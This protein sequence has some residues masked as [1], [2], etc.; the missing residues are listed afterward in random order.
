MI[1]E[2]VLLSYKKKIDLTILRPATVCGYS[3]A[4]RL[5]VAINALTFGALEKNLITV[6]GGKQIRPNLTMHDM[7]NAYKF[8][9]K[10]KSK[11]N[12]EIKKIIFNLG[13]E[14]LSIINMAKR[15]QKKIKTGSKILVKTSNDPRS[16]RQNSDRIIKEGFIPEKKIEDAI[17]E[18]KEKF[19]QNKIKKKDSYFRI[20]TLKMIKA[21]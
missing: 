19:L 8:A 4:M 20:N 6:F 21:K 10:R 11:K 1:G 18:I 3:P 12:R 7:I 17:I 2:R 5:D 16:Y 14:N 13:F 15:I 9:L